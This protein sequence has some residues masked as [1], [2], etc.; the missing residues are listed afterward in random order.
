MHDVMRFWL[1]RG[2]DGFRIDVVHC[3]GRD[4]ALPD[5]EPPWDQIPHCASNEHPST[6]EHIRACAALVDAYPGDRVLVGETALPGTRWVAP[7]YGD[8]DELH[9]AFNFA[10]THAPWDADAW[11]HRI[12]RVVEE[13]GPRG[14]LAHLGAVQP[15]RAPPPHP[16]R[17]QS[18]RRARAA[19]VAVLTQRGTPF[20]YAGEELGPGGRR[21]PAGPGGGP[22]RSRRVPRADAL[23][24]RRRARL[25]RPTRG[26][27]F[28]P[29]AAE[30]I[31]R[32]TA[33]DPGS[34]LHLYRRLLA[35]RRGS[36]AP[37][38]WATSSC[39]TRPRACSR[40]DGRRSTPTAATDERTVARRASGP[41]PATCRA[42]RHR[43]GG[44]RRHRRGRALRRRPRARRRGGARRPSLDEGAARAGLEHEPA[45]RRPAPSDASPAASARIGSPTTSW[46]HPS[47]SRPPSP[48][49]R[50]SMSDRV[51][52]MAASISRS[53]A[54]CAAH[55]LTSD[56]AARRDRSTA[57]AG[58]TCTS[59]RG[60]STPCGDHV[61][62]LLGRAALALAL[63]EAADAPQVRLVRGR[64]LGHRHERQVGE[65]EAHGPVDLGGPA[66]AP[67][68]QRL[69]HGGGPAAQGPSLLDPPPRPLGWGGHRGAGAVDLALVERPLQPAAGLEL[70][71][72]PIVELVQV[73]DVGRRVGHR[74]RRAAGGR[75]SR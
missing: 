65:E 32:G 19:A 17:R 15:R 9:L 23:G 72:E 2:V 53:R 68:G 14:G 25:G 12:D 66:L 55:A 58:G 8:G 44:Q 45:V 31:G 42:R 5:D 36:P 3:I 29:E 22:R 33:A 64:A 1:D 59:A 16:L 21:R 62:Q 20:L 71:H 43:R 6:H 75:A 54:R 69:R 57:S 13:L 63:V 7:Y 47:A 30:R 28:P 70:G 49:S 34:I 10:V 27:P 11:R 40:G 18:R 60:S 39:S 35:A 74:V 56:A 67:R 24:P 41:T 38:G 51:A 46:R 61:E 48:I 52:R 50:A 4:P 73:G 26:C 37:A